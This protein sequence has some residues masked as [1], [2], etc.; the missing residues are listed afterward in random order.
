METET[1]TIYDFYFSQISS[2]RQND[3]AFLNPYA[4]KCLFK[5]EEYTEKIEHNKKPISIFEDLAFI[6]TGTGINVKLA[7]RN[8]IINN[9]YL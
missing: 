7:K 9:G 1:E 2:D 8:P 5:D 4:T 3:L 6:G